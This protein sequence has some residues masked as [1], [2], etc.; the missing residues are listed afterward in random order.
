MV[1]SAHT[2][3]GYRCEVDGRVIIQA[4]SYGRGVSVVDVVLD[5]RSR[6][7]DARRTR[8]INLPVLNDGTDADPRAAL[9]EKLAAATPEPYAALLRAQRPDTAVAARVAQYTA[10]VAPKAGEA[11]GRIA[12]RYTRASAPGGRS[13]SA[14]GRPDRRCP[15]RRHPRAGLRGGARIAFMNPGGIRTDLDCATP[16]CTVSFGAAFSMQPFGNSLVVMTLTGG[17][18]EGP[19][20]GAA[21]GRLPASRASCSPP[22]ASATNGMPRRRPASG[23][24]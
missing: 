21:A 12:G 13:D 22:A 10:I 17:A 24:R 5:P 15:A 20:G 2:H 18:A 4:T 11:V 19:A 14:A 3:Q 6:D 1:F 23:C 16:P 7:V 8:S 9:R